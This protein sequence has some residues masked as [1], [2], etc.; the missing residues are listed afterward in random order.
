ECTDQ[1]KKMW[2]EIHD[3]I[4]TNDL[5]Q[6]KTL[7]SKHT[8]NLNSFNLSTDRDTILHSAAKSKNVK[9]M[10]FVLHRISPSTKQRMMKMKNDQQQF[11]SD[12]VRIWTPST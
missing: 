6:L 5:E 1:K 4:R 2:S 9:M 10:E 8:I 11:P 12:L 3:C 7:P